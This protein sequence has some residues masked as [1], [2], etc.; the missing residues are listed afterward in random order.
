MPEP[1]PKCIRC[2]KDPYARAREALVR[3]KQAVARTNATVARVQS[4]LLLEA[5]PVAGPTRGKQ[6]RDRQIRVTQAE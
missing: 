6:G 5:V 3:A 2:D 4:A 1:E